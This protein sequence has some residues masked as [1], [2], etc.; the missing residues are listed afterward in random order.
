[1]SSIV[2]IL[3]VIRGMSCT[4][5]GK[6]ARYPPIDDRAAMIKKQKGRKRES[7]LWNASSS[8]RSRN[9][10]QDFV[11]SVGYE[12]RVRLLTRSPIG[13]NK[14]RRLC[15]PQ[16]IIQSSSRSPS[17]EHQRFL[18]SMLKLWPRA[19]CA[20]VTSSFVF[21]PKQWSF[22]NDLLI[23][24]DRFLSRSNVSSSEL[25]SIKYGRV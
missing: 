9:S 2:E 21:L 18:I 7:K 16:G 22:R 17:Q 10:R 11:R 19:T 20:C 3:R 13:H 25:K 24:I 8:A 1:M 4:H 5:C 14:T 23:D 15:I 12:T 6:R